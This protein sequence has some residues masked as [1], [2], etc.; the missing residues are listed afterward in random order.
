M[1]T[2]TQREEAR[3]EI[4]QGVNDADATVVEAVL[5]LCRSLDDV[6]ERLE[7]ASEETRKSVERLSDD[8]SK[9]LKSEAWVVAM[10]AEQRTL[11]I[12]R[13]GEEFK[14]RRNAWR[15]SARRVGRRVGLTEAQVEAA[16]TWADSEL[17]EAIEIFGA[18]F[19]RRVRRRA[20]SSDA[21]GRTGRRRVEAIGV[22]EGR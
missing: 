22:E 15:M 5:E 6:A 2:R 19:A 21:G 4:M 14:A 1:R 9:H 10:K 13:D 3:R 7:A 20:P 17:A 12:A 11:Y 8:F 18:Q 16:R